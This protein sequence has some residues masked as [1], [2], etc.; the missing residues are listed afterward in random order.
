MKSVRQ[1][2]ETILS[3]AF[4]TQD[5]I[6]SVPAQQMRMDTTFL[7]E[8]KKSKPNPAEPE[9]QVSG[10]FSTSGESLFHRQG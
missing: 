6:V 7:Q 5:F 8:R 4:L 10:I 9:R 2:F 1:A 3:K